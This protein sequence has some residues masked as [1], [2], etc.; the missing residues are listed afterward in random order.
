MWSLG[1]VCVCAEEGEI[2]FGRLESN[3]EGE[4]AIKGL[5]VDPSNYKNQSLFTSNEL[6]ILSALYYFLN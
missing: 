2:I 1:H 3:V 5:R 4:I 6:Q